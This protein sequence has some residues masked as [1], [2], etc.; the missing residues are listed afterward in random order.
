MIIV[1]KDRDSICNFDNVTAVYL[2]G[3]S[4]KIKYTNDGF[5]RIGEYNSIKEAEIALEILRNRLRSKSEVC[6]LPT[7]DE[8]KAYI[9]RVPESKQRARN[10]KKTVRRGAS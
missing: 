2:N 8:V 9:V 4:V 5:A 6:E 10:G 7:D 3:N 1:S